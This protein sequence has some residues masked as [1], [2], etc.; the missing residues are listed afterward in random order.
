[1]K[2]IIDGMEVIAQPGQ[3]LPGAPFPHGCR[4]AAQ[5]RSTAERHG[6]GL[7]DQSGALRLQKCHGGNCGGYFRSGAGE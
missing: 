5:R 1:M 4:C 7:S 3:S 6:H 2:L